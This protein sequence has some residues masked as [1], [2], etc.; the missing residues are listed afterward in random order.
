[1]TETQTQV[2]QTGVVRKLRD[3]Y[4]FIAGN[5]GI[6]YFLH[7]TQMV[8]GGKTFRELQVSDRVEFVIGAAPKGPRALE[9]RV[10]G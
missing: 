3:G 5:D 1:M 8:K 9:V 7:W 2:N 10:V 6:D 4:G